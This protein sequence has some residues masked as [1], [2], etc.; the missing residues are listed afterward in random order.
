V[1]QLNQTMQNMNRT[2]EEQIEQQLVHTPQ[3][4]QILRLRLLRRIS[5]ALVLIAALALFLL[6]LPPTSRG[7]L[8]R[9]LIENRVLIGLLIVFA[10][11]TNSLLLSS[12]QRLDVWLF[13]ALN[14]RGYHAPWTDILMWISTQIG[15]LWFATLLV[16]ISYGLGD[17]HFAVDL[18]LGSLTLMLV[19]T[20]LKAVTDRVRP[21]NLLRETRVTGWHEPGL[22]F[23]S[24]HTAQTF[25]LMTL[26]I[27]H[28][29][30]P[31]G[32]AVALYA[33]AVLVAFTRV[34]LGVHYPRDVIAGAVL[35]LIWA[36]LAILVAPYL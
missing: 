12:G 2:T 7:L 3:G 25:L 36:N 19:V 26:T 32:I 6:W 10:L 9:S 18:T 14:L 16:V 24:G 28:F 34:Y 21:F 22:S 33:I 29:H 11:I 15:H 4:E 23:P 30:L 5:F 8:V 35:G 1:T 27:S 31:F 20:I 17:R 13:Q